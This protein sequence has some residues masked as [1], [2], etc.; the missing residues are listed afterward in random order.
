MEEEVIDENTVNF[1]ILI[2][3]IF[4]NSKLKHIFLII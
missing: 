2:K 4:I 3:F 1:K